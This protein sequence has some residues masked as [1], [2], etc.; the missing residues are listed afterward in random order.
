M[1]T[2]ATVVVSMSGVVLIVAA[3]RAA[4][5]EGVWLFLPIATAILVAV[6]VAAGLDA[7]MSS[8]V[9]WSVLSVALVIGTVGSVIQAKRRLE[10]DQR[11]SRA[12]ERSLI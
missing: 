1:A 11:R 9:N 3:G 2:V 10:G 8:N 4:R 5:R 6:I 12:D 7:A